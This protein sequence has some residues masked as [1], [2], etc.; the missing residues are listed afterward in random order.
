MSDHVNPQR[1]PATPWARTAEAMRQ[2]IAAKLAID[3]ARLRYHDPGEKSAMGVDG[4]RWQIYYRDEWQ[5]LPWHFDGPLG[6]TRELV[7]AKLGVAE[8]ASEPPKD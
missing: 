6:V 5:D 3:P 8:R 1:L 2:E 4:E 7:R